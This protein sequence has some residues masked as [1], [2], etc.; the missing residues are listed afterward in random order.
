MVDERKRE[1][2]DLL[3]VVILGDGIDFLRRLLVVTPLAVP[4]HVLLGM[5]GKLHIG[6]HGVIVKVHGGRG[7]K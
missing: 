3:K 6:D 7:R 1:N 2:H 5:A 4:F